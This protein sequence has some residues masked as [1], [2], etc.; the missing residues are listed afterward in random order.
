M[1][2]GLEHL[3]CEERLRDL[4]LFNLE[5]RGLRG[6][7]SNTYKYLKDKSQVDE[8]RLFSLVPRNST[9]VNGQKQEHRTFHANIRKDFFII[10]DGALAQAA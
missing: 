9:R 6:N 4:G 7:L 10:C 2:K 5:K 3:L 1:I 8:S